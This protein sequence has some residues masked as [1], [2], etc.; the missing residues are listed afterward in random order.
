[1]DLPFLTADLSGIGGALRARAEDFVV[2]EVP[3]YPPSGAGD[4]VFARIEK[5]D[6]ATPFAVKLIAAALGVQARDIGTAGLKDRR[7]VTT[8][9][10]SLPPPVTPDAVAALALEGIRVLEVARHNHKLRT[11]HLRANRFRL[12]VR[13][14]TDGAAERA[15]AILVRLAEA[16]G[17]P[18]FYGEQRFGR[19]GDNAAR[20]RA[21]LLGERSRDRSRD[22][23]FVS[24]LQAELFNAWLTARLADDLYRT[25]L[26]GDVMHKRPR[27]G[28]PGGMFDCA[29]AAAETARLAAGEIVPTGPMF[30][31][32]M[33]R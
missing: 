31:D 10:I 15:R 33:R 16:P 4:H 25:A 32:R 14:V 8:Q 21:I 1:M 9:W 19:A 3:A 26:P 27:D 12:R 17:A 30:G 28:A 18:N 20:G 23:F 7:A 22:R 29:D 11:G 13:G 24:S 6:H 2:D 5:R